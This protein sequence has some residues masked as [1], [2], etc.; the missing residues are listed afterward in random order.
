LSIYPFGYLPT[1]LF[2]SLNSS[3]PLASELWS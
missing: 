1:I 3:S 2:S